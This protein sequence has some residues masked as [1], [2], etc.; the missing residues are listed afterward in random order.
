MK[1]RTFTPSEM[2]QSYL[3]RDE[4]Y[5]HQPL[6]VQYLLSVCYM[7]GIFL[8]PEDKGVNKTDNNS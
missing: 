3:T 1:E 6:Y 4:L 8:D 2:K 5:I 7:L